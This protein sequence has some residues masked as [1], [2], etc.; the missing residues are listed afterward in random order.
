MSAPV[1]LFPG[2]P[3]VRRKPKVRRWYPVGVLEAWALTENVRDGS[4]TPFPGSP[5][6]RLTPRP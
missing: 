6:C 5:L 2:T 3:K 1:I 4:V